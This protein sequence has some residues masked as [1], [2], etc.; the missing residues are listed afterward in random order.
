M[1][2]PIGH[3]EDMSSRAVQVL[4]QVDH[5]ACEDTRV[6]R[7][8]CQHYNVTTALKRHDSHNELASTPGLIALLQRGESI[9][10]VSD[11][12]TPGINDPG[13]RLVAAAAEAK[14]PIRT[15]PGPSALTAALAGSGLPV[16]PFTFHGF[17][18]KKAGKRRRLLKE[19]STG[20]HAFFCPARDLGPVTTDL[21]EVHREAKVVVGREL[22][23]TY[24][25]WYRG[26]ANTVRLRLEE[27]HESSRGEAVVLLHVSGITGDI[28][29]DAIMDALRPL[30]A[31]G[32]RAKE[33]A[34]QV[35]STLAIPRRRAYQLALS[36][37]T[38]D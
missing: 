32:A 16:V 21:S 12:G 28:D 30:I 27:D 4:Q 8:L 19:L 29:D 2:T 25:S 18:P 33:A 38:D 24:E 22:T 10:L 3:L 13:Q 26:D 9:A 15:I 7:R 1:A 37:V 34:T 5:I 14:L 17:I 36:L 20:T 11:A 35:A 31:G 23:K 6:T